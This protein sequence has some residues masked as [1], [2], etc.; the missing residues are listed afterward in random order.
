M[1]KKSLI[2]GLAIVLVVSILIYANTSKQAANYQ[3]IG[4]LLTAKGYMVQKGLPWEKGQSDTYTKSTVFKINAQDTVNL[5]E[6]GS[7][8]TAKEGLAELS[9]RLWIT[10][11]HFFWKSRFVVI[12]LGFDEKVIRDLE[13]ILGKEYNP[14]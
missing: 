9:R 13:T 5:L 7:Y 3:D 11:P 14:L 12:Y 4:N 1:I 6:Y 2:V 8:Y 10:T